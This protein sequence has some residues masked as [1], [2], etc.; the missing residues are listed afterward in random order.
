[1]ISI[2][3]LPEQSTEV[4]AWVRSIHPD[5]DLTLWYTDNSFS[6]RTVLTPGITPQEVL[7][8][9]VDHDEHDPYIEYPQYFH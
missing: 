2:D 6:G 7:D 8:N 3:G 1:M 4:A 9:W 5:P